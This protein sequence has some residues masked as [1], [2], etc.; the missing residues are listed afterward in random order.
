MTLTGGM[1]MFGRNKDWVELKER[2]WEYFGKDSF[3]RH[4]Y[5]RS[6]GAYITDLGKL[7]WYNRWFIKL[8]NRNRPKDNRT[9]QQM[10]NDYG[11]V[12]VKS[13][14]L[15]VDITNLELARKKLEEKKQSEQRN[16]D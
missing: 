16:D 1:V 15:G 13:P 11:I 6:N 5:R 10:M 7:R 4:E 8:M 14:Q 3:I 2:R 9:M 12:S